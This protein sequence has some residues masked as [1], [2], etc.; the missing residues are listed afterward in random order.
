MVPQFANAQPNR[1]GET[2]TDHRDSD[3][4]RTNGHE[5]SAGLAPPTTPPSDHSCR[6]DRHGNS[7]HRTA[8]LPED[9]GCRHRPAG[10]RRRDQPQV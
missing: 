5:T 10:E 4:P 2:R 3:D 7:H 1:H 6:G 9:S 8:Y